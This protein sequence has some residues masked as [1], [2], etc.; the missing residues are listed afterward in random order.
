MT[1]IYK[2][3]YTLFIIKELNLDYHLLNQDDNN[4]YTFINN[5]TKYQ[6]IKEHMLYLSK[7]KIILANNLQ[8][9]P[10]MYW[11]PKMHKNPISYCFII[12]SPLCSIKLL[13]KDITSIFKFF[14][15]KGE[16]YHAKGKV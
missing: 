10:V 2:D 12:A 14:Y 7:H 6:I 8:G 15:K 3:F 4:T 1:F 9:L 11:I 16:R 13:S 5:K